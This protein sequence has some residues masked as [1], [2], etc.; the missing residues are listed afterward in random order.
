MH[1]MHILKLKGSSAI[2][3]ISPDA[4]VG[5]AAARLAEKRIG[6]LVVSTKGSDIAGIIS[7]RDVVRALARKAGD[8]L[9]MTVSTL[10]TG[11]VET[12]APTDTANSVLE[13]MTAG[14]FRHMPV[15]EDGKMVGLVSIGDVVKA[16]ITE[17]EQEN[18]AMA[19]MLSG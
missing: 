1:V 4:S 17:I 9:T 3:T 2:E 8:C 7:E 18:A 12:C 6:A 10:M 19:E 14:R 16:R 5:D 11:M 13:R 15:V